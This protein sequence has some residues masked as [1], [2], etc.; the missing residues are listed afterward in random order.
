MNAQDQSRSPARPS[1]LRRSWDND[2]W[3]CLSVAAATVS[4]LAGLY[5]AMSLA[6]VARYPLVVS[7]LA[8]AAVWT[9]LSC[10]AMAAWARDGIGAVLRAG[11]VVDA[12]AVLLL[13]LCQMRVLPLTAALE[14][15]L[16]LAAMC[17]FCVATVRLGQR[18]PAQ[19]ALAALTGTILLATMASPLWA[20]NLLETAPLRKA[21][22]AAAIY[23]N[24]LY[25]IWSVEDVRYI[26]HESGLMYRISGI[27]DYAPPAPQWWAT[28]AIYT[29]AAAVI[30]GANLLRKRLRRT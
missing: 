17:L 16:I 18:R 5:L 15:Y 28:V 9:A 8:V 1:P 24:A 11:A 19:L 22:L 13:V 6:G 3:A 26:W 7:L 30:A 20:P 4:L 25:S 23:P 21:A 10:G 12:V 27:R 2:G 29:L 14:I